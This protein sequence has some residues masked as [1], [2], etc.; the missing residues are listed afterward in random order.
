MEH[1]SKRPQ[2]IW[3]L[4]TT[5]IVLGCVVLSTA[6]AL[7]STSIVIKQGNTVVGNEITVGANGETVTL[8]VQ[9]N[10]T[11]SVS[12]P[13]GDSWIAPHQSGNEITLTIIKNNNALSRSTSIKVYAGEA[14]RTVTI[15]QNGAVSATPTLFIDNNA[16][17]TQFS[18]SAEENGE[19]KG[20][21][22]S[23]E[24]G[25]GSWTVSE[26]V[27]WISTTTSNLGLTLIL[28]PNTNT[29]TRT[30][31]V[32]IN[33]S[34]ITKTIKISQQ[35][36]STK[37]STPNQTVTTPPKSGTSAQPVVE[38]T[39]AVNMSKWT[40][41]AEAASSTVNVTKSFGSGSVSVA[42]SAQSSWLTV[43]KAEGD[44]YTLSVQENTTDASRSAQVT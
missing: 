20:W 9:A 25:S 30:A 44:S 8:D 19:S 32:L 7:A 3:V 42:K 16:S 38:A 4:W 43:T 21:L 31:D 2:P 12:K 14:N 28:E 29:E 27:S 15:K 39:L 41:K 10:S 33:Y 11:I 35:G 40:P 17:E 22:I 36:G 24:G 6:N 13:S 5:M 37:Q 26:N 34:G 23:A 18:W 1:R